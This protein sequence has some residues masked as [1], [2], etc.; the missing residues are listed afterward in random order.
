MRKRLALIFCLLLVSICG[1][2]GCN[3]DPYS[4]MTI[5][6]DGLSNDKVQQLYI[7]QTLEEGN[8]AY[9]YDEIGF[10]VK[11][12]G[13][14]NDIDTKLMVSGW[15]GYIEKP[16]LE[17]LG[18]GITRITSKPLSVGEGATGK[19]TLNIKTAEGNK[20]LNVNFNI[21]LKLNNF[22]FKSSALQAVSNDYEVVLNDIEGLIEYYPSNSTQ[23]D[24]T[25]SVAV[26]TRGS[27]TGEYIINDRIDGSII[28]HVDEVFEEYSEYKY[29]EVIVDKNTNKQILKIY[30]YLMTSTGKIALDNDGQPI[31]SSFPKIQQETT[32]QMEGIF[33]DCITLRAHSTS[34]DTSIPDKFLDVEVVPSAGEVVL[35]MN[36]KSGEDVFIN[37]DS[38][39]N[40]NVVLIDIDNKG[41]VLTS[42]EMSYYSQRDLTFFVKDPLQNMG[43]GT[44]LDDYEI[45]IKEN[46]VPEDGLPVSISM[47]GNRDN[48]NVSSITAGTY[49]HTFILEHKVYKGLFTQEIKVNFKVLAIP[50]KIS[51][52]GN[53]ISCAE[54]NDIVTTIYNTYP[55]G[56]YGTKFKVD[57]NSDFKYFVFY[58]SDNEDT[59]SKTLKIRRDG[60]GAEVTFAVGKV[61]D[62]GTLYLHSP[63]EGYDYTNFG[64]KS[65]FYLSHSMSQIPEEPITIYI[66]IIFSMADSSYSQEITD[67]YFN[68]TLIYFPIH[69]QIENGLESI[70]FTQSSYK[71]N[72]NNQNYLYEENEFGEI[73]NYESGLKLWD[74]PVGRSY[75][76]CVKSITYDESLI[77]VYNVHNEETNTTSLYVK[78]VKDAPVGKTKIVIESFNGLTNSVWVENYIPTIYEYNGDMADGDTPIMPLACSVD[79]YSSGFLYYMT[80]LDSS[81]HEAKYTLYSTADDTAIGAYDSVATLFMIVNAEQRIKF[82]DYRIVNKKLIEIDITSKVRVSFSYS[83]YVTYENGVLKT[84]SLVTLDKDQ[85]IIMTV[86][87]TSGYEDFDENGNSIY[88]PLTMTHKIKIYIYEPL[89]GV[90]VISSKAVDL[91]IDNSLGYYNKDLSRHTIISTFIPNEIKLGS[92]WN[93]SD[94]WGLKWWNE[95]EQKYEYNHPVELR[96]EFEDLLNSV[97]INSKGQELKIKSNNSSA[98]RMV[99]YKDLFNVNV[100]KEKYECNVHNVISED[101]YNWLNQNGYTNTELIDYILKQLFKENINFTVN[102]Y[103]NQ[104]NK[105]QN[106]NSVRF[107]AKYADRI[108]QLKLNVED[109][110]VYFE[111]RKNASGEYIPNVSNIEIEYTIDNADV[112]NKNISL[113]NFDTLYYY[114]TVLPNPTGNSGK[115][116]ITPKITAGIGEL[117]LTPEDNINTIEN[118]VIVYYNESSNLLQSFRIKVADG[119]SQYPFEIR[120]VNDYQQMLEDIESGNYY[121]YVITR[122]INMN[123]F[124]LNNINITNDNNKNA[125]TFSLSG[126]HTYIRNNQ[127]ITIYNSI[128]NLEINQTISSLN[129]DLNVGLF[130]LLENCVTMDNISIKNAYIT[131]I[132]NSSSSY[133]VNIGILAGTI[134]GAILKACSVS[135]SIKVIR[136]NNEL[137][138]GMIVGGMVGKAVKSAVITG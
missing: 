17:Y 74:L 70:D 64:A 47:I 95:E 57:T 60:D 99:Y 124:S 103:I 98:Y 93:D 24:I 51:V 100:D 16:N 46:I 30:P 72:L 14:G 26:P 61:L 9:V 79:K 115:I 13:A 102:V 87:Y 133:N 33:Y 85:P 71:V 41:G 80:G 137:T 120:D 78:Y 20:D 92:Q 73:V 90:E 134:D 40:Y 131:I 97:I 50:F 128:Y 119:S 4:K 83:N 11:V 21:D 7:T 63:E 112:I 55:R 12:S 28:Y 86:T 88:K 34:G 52:N 58:F 91:Y 77:N 84:Y 38:S 121:H 66:G 49:T 39:G 59:L 35:A 32:G 48:F 69:L 81:N 111:V 19:F 44:Y 138:T 116:V 135:G 114:A 105:L 27:Q 126:K 67:N 130:G 5:N 132:D 117:T 18:N 136:N 94:D 15:E 43:V 106:I 118:G 62:D 54:T 42:D 31:P 125:T 109:D 6:A 75:G 101:L 22:Y 8:I 3:N 56:S 129:K 113:Y 108:N 107:T 10:T 36:S 2:F 53:S 29:A 96:Y 65:S 76:S 123:G 104:F 45:I 68:K 1:I 82:F 23:K 37:K 89:E 25:Y 110:G 122:D 127:Q